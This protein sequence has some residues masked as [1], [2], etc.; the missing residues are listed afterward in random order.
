M[1]EAELFKTTLMGG[2]DKE[3]V[4]EQFRRFRDRAADEK[5]KL[6]QEIAIKDDKIAQLTKRLD[7]KDVQQTRMEEEIRNKYQ[8]YID[9]YENIAKLVFDASVRAEE[10]IASAKEEC[11]AMRAQTERECEQLRTEAEAEAR[12][13]VEAVQSEVDEKLAEG[14]K[15]YIAVQDEMNGIV[16]LIN[17]AQLRFMAS[18]QEVH[19]IVSTMPESLREIEEEQFEQEETEDELSEEMEEMDSQLIDHMEEIFSEDEDI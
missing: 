5:A 18:Y 19:N 14:K 6:K 7:L 4:L 16:E 9:K 2:Y 10:M 13:R 17:Q 3:D 11:M 8:K 1:S 15:K 12:K